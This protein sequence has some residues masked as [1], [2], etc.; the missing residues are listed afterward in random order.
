M[1]EWAARIWTNPCFHL[2]S[3]C[4]QSLVSMMVCQGKFGKI[5]IRMLGR[6][7]GARGG[8]RLATR[9]NGNSRVTKLHAARGRGAE[10]QFLIPG[11]IV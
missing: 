5:Y 10:T 1:V 11:E 9:E 7:I 2:G 3:I 8:G 6:E 4:T